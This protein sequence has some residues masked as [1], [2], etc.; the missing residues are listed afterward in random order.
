MD[1]FKFSP[2]LIE[3]TASD[4]YTTVLVPVSSGIYTEFITIVKLQWTCFVPLHFNG[5]VD[6]EFVDVNHMAFHPSKKNDVDC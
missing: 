2:K 6:R 5:Y 1:H 3:K 4:I